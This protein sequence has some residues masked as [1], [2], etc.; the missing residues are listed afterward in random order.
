M[1][2]GLGRTGPAHLVIQVAGWVAWKAATTTMVLASMVD[3]QAV[4]VT[5]KAAWGTAQVKGPG[6]P[7]NRKGQRKEKAKQDSKR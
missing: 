4:K 5:P 3:T 6:C 1:G 7:M 2:M